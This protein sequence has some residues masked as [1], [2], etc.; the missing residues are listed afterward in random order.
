MAVSSGTAALHIALKLAGV[1]EDDEVLVPALTFVATA[2]A[3][4]YC[5]ATPH[6]VDSDS[7]TLGVDPNKLHKYLKANTHQIN[8]CCVNIATG[9]VTRALIPMHTFGHPSDM[10]RLLQIEANFNIT[11]VEDAAEALGSIYKGRHVGT[12]GL[13]GTLSFNGNKILLL[14][15]RR[16]YSNKRF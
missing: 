5:G 10:D 11:L 6:F 14:P 13:L 4:S 12:F 1:K 3:V 2:N 16:R 9:K 8:G 15:G 7:L